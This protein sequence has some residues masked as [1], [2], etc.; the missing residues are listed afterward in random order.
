[1]IFKKIIDMYKIYMKYVYEKFLNRRKSIAFSYFQAENQI[2]PK[3]W[4]FK[5][6]KHHTRH[7]VSTT[8]TK[9]HN[10]HV[11]LSEIL[12]SFIHAFCFQII[13]ACT[14]Y[15]KAQGHAPTITFQLFLRHFEIFIMS[16]FTLSNQICCYSIINY[17]N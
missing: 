11:W 7:K 6:D 9:S 17:I 4:D 10:S 5:Q 12:S 1:M 16:C 2:I 8:L 14:N 3:H 15:G 13:K